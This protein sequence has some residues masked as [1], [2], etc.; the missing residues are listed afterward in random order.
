MKQNRIKENKWLAY[1][2]LAWTESIICADD[3][4]KDEIK[5]YLEAIKKHS[6]I[7]VKILLHLGCGAGEYDKI[8]KKYFKVTGVD[9]SNGMLKIAKSKNPEVIYYR[10]NMR[11]VELNK[12]FDVVVIPDS[13]GYMTKTGDLKKTLA[14]AYKH[15]NPGGVLLVTSH[16]AEEFK[17]NNFVYTGAKGDTKI[18]IFE[19]N[20]ILDQAKTKYEAVLIYLICRKGDFKIYTDRHLI[21][22]FKRDIWL[23][24]LKNAGFSIVKQI[25]MNHLYDRF[26]L[27]QGEYILRVFVCVKPEISCSKK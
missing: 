10:A 23:K 2:E 4:Y 11:N 19:N 3:D 5:V 13:I 16:I 14:T 1:N 9:I 17:D 21:G 24:L 25:K 27:E 7:K 8:F 18:T 22:L 15:L 12:S 6:K 20:H 26:V